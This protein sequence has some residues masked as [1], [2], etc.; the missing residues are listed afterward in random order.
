MCDR[1]EQNLWIGK[2]G[3]SIEYRLDRDTEISEIRLVFDNDMNRRYHNMPCS[4]P[5]VETR[6]KLP[7]TLIKEYSIE[8]V[9][10]SGDKSVIH[11]TDNHQRLVKHSVKTNAKLVRFVPVSTHGCD[12]FRL[13]DFEIK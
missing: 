6:F 10:E 2:A 1:G 13:F 9:T 11:V 4:Y 5:L 8:L 7:K 3:D 12:D